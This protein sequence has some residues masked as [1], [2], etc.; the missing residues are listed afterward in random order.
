MHSH[1]VPPLIFS[2]YLGSE[3][4]GFVV[5]VEHVERRAYSAYKRHL[6]NRYKKAAVSDIVH[7]SNLLIGYQPGYE[8]PHTIFGFGVDRWRGTIVSVT[9]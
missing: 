2:E 1:N 5:V 7:G 9:I 6:R 8:L 3:I 4:Y